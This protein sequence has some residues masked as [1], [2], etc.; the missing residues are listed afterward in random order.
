MINKIIRAIDVKSLSKSKRWENFQCEENFNCGRTKNSSELIN[1]ILKILSLKISAEP[2]KD[3]KSS[4]EVA[5]K[6][7][8]KVEKI[9]KIV[10]KGNEKTKREFKV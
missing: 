5:K 9:L 8:S 2:S 6:G 3:K 10:E 7:L 1:L 4:K